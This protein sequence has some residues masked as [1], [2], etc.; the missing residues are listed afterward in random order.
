MD[1]KAKKSDLKDR[2]YSGGLQTFHVEDNRDFITY[3]PSTLSMGGSYFYQLRHEVAGKY[4]YTSHLMEEKDGILNV[5]L[6]KRIANRHYILGRSLE[7]KNGV[8]GF[9]KRRMVLVSEEGSSNPS[10]YTRCLLSGKIIHTNDALGISWVS[11][12]LPLQKITE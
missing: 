5:R 10:A 6:P 11:K 7:V 1:R 2:S 8:F 9:V 4:F 12:N 3:F